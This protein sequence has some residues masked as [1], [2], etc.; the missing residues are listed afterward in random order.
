MGFNSYVNEVRVRRSMAD[1]EKNPEFHNFKIAYLAE[2]Y[3]FSSHSKYSAAFKAVTGITPSL[4][5]AR[6][7][8]NT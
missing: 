2:K 3:G 1:L 6:L 5:I 8:Q 7:Q 4:F